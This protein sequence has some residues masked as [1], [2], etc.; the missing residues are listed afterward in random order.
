M[1]LQAHLCI[2]QE[3]V[4]E[5][6]DFVT[7]FRGAGIR[8]WLDWDLLQSA[9]Y[10]VLE[11]YSRSRVSLGELETVWYIK[12]DGSLGDWRNQGNRRLR[13][14]EAAARADFPSAESARYMQ[15]LAAGMRASTTPSLLVL[16]CYQTGRGGVLILDGNHRAVAAV[17][18][19]VDVRLLIFAIT[20]PDNPLMLPDLLQEKGI[21]STPEL[22]ARHRAEIEAKFTS[23]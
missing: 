9:N 17:K 21:D 22:W 12:S 8:S 2:T 20:G 14:C 19:E 7:I 4:I 18:A 6:H 15:Q 16:P 11:K 3:V 1:P 23:G 5:I 10:S 13:V